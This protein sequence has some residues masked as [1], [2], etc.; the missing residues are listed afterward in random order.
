MRSATVAVLFFLFVFFYVSFGPSVSAQDGV[1]D[2]KNV[3]GV[4]GENVTVPLDAQGDRIAGYEANFTFDPGTVNLTGINGINIGDPVANTNNTV[5][6]SYLTSSNETGTDDPRLANLTFAVDPSPPDNFTNLSFVVS[7][8][9]LN[10][11][12][13]IIDTGTSNGSITFL[14][15]PL[16]DVEV[17]NTNSPVVEGEEVEVVTNVANLGEAPGTQ[18]ITLGV[19]RSVGQTD[20]TQVS[21]GPNG[22]TNLNLSW[23]TTGGDAGSYGINVSS[24]DDTDTEN[25]TVL[26]AP[27]FQVNITNTTSPVVEGG[28]LNVTANVTNT[29]GATGTQRV[30]LL[31]FEG[32]SVDNRT[33]SL[34]SGESETLNLSWDTEVGENGTDRITLA[35]NDTADTEEVTLEGL[36]FFEVNVT[37]FDS[38]TVAGGT[39][40]LNGTVTN[41]GDLTGTQTLELS[42]SGVGTVDSESVT[43][44]GGANSTFNL[45]WDTSVGDPGDYT[46][47]V[48]SD[49]ST[50]SL[51]L[52][53]L[54]P[55]LFDVELVELNDPVVEGGTLEATVRVENLGEAGGSQEINLTDVGFSGLERDNATVTVP[56]GGSVE[57]AL[58]WN[59]KIGENGT[60]DVAVFSDDTTDTEAVEVLRQDEP[61][62]RVD[63]V[64]AG[65]VTAGQAVVVEANVT[66]IGGGNDTQE[67]RLRDTGFDNRLRDTESVSLSGGESANILLSWLTGSGDVGTG[68]V[69]ARSDN[70]TDSTPVTITPSTPV[71][72]P[73]FPGIGGGTGGGTPPTGDQQDEPDDQEQE[74]PEDDGPTEPGGGTPDDSE[75]VEE[76]EFEFS[77]TVSE[78]EVTLPP[79]PEIDDT[80]TVIDDTT[81]DV[82]TSITVEAAVENVGGASG[83]VSADLIVDGEVTDSKQVTLG[84]GENKS[85]SFEVAFGEPGEYEV[86]VGDSAPE[87]VFVSAQ[88]DEE[89]I[90]VFLGGLLAV[91]ILLVAII[92]ILRRRRSEEST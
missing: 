31:D 6:W 45:S 29:G 14:D 28:V 47:T 46:A 17:L 7:D 54:E 12:S 76:P 16:F 87:T 57:L 24:R 75:P 50:E 48:S 51:A 21:L 13:K 19:N 69:T 38:E 90:A 52:E 70:D 61:Y 78:T 89:G 41:S 86:R 64:G 15:P 73:T 39:A 67:I 65:N 5:G 3:S 26:E 18:N 53:V 56:G 58:T 23:Q 27:F 85:V 2:L 71:G 62:F 68:D 25:I 43:L 77:S 55:P 35:S 82:E 42:V 33:V 81:P 30:D 74:V 84:P 92:E 1:V 34:T 91:L 32:V 11:E 63:V 9:L 80:A 60:A 4:K 59:T 88:E 8:T 10:N 40:N 22:M 79:D 20:R 72:V 66:N 36:P 49:N 37:D 83:T 44:G